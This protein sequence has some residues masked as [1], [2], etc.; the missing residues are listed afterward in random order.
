[1]Q[2]AQGGRYVV[3]ISNAFGTAFSR[4][5]TLSVVERTN[6]PVILTPPTSL[7]CF[8]GQTAT[9]TVEASGTPPLCYQWFRDEVPL[10]GQTNA[11]LVFPSVQFA[12]AGSYS[13]TVSNAA[14]SV[15]CGY[16]LLTVLPAAGQPGSV[17]P[18]F[19][20]GFGADDAVNALALRPDGRILIGGA[21]TSFDGVPREHLAQ[22]HGDGQVD[23][24]FDPGTGADFNL[25]AVA[26]QRDGQALI[27]G[28]FT[29]FNGQPQRYLARLRADGSVDAG[30]AP[31]FNEWGWVLAVAVQND[32]RIVIGG[33][34][35]SVNGE[36]RNR[37]ARLNADGSLDA[38][39]QPT[40]GVDA[41][42]STVMTLAVQPDGKV[43]LGGVFERVNG[44]ARRHIARLNAD[45]T[46][47][48]T[49]DPGTGAD[50]TVWAVAWQPD[51]KIVMGGYFTSVHGVSR[52]GIARLHANGS[53]D[54]SFDPG[55]GVAHADSPAVHGLALQSD[56]KIL[57]AG[58]FVVMN[59]VRRTHL[60]RL[61]PDGSLDPA[62][63]AD[64]ECFGWGGGLSDVV[65]QPDGQVLIAGNLENVNGTP[66]RGIARLHNQAGVPPCIPA[67]ASLVAWWPGNRDGMDVVGG[68]HGVSH[69]AA[70]APG[71]VGPAF[72]FDGSSYLEVPEAPALRLQS[73][74]TIEFWVRRERLEEPHYIV[75]KGGDWT[76][77]EQNYAVAL[78]T[79]AY[80]HCLHFLFAGGW[81][82]GGRIADTNWHHCAV[83]ARHGETNPALYIDGVQ[84]AV[85]YGEGAETIEL[86]PSTRPL[87][88]GAQIDPQSGWFYYHRGRI[89][90]LSFYDRVLSGGEIEAIYRA[91]SS[92]KCLTSAPPAFVERRIETPM[93]QLATTPP[94]SVS[95]YAVEDQPP[96]GWPVTNISHSGVWDGATG[97]VKFG[98]FYDA[99][100]RA[101][102]YEVG[103][104]VWGIHCALG[105]FCFSGRA[106][107]D[108][109]NS[110]VGGQ[111]CLAL[112][113]YFPADVTPADQQISIGEVTA[114][115]AAWRRGSNWLCHPQGIPIDYVTRAAF[116]WRAGEC[117]VVDPAIT[118]QPLWWVA[119]GTSGGA[120]VQSAGTQVFNL[121]SA[122][123]QMPAVFVPGEPFTVTVATQ[124]GTDTRAHAVE[125]AIPTGWTVS[126][127]NG[128]GDFDAAGGKVKWGPF[129]DAT[130]RTL[131]YR[132]NPP[133]TA[134]GI[135]SFSGVM[136][137]DGASV[138]I[139]GAGQV[140]EACRITLISPPASGPLQLTLSGRLGARCVVEA[141]SDLAT[142]TVLV[143]VTN[144][145]GRLMVTDPDFENHRARFYRARLLD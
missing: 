31:Q 42:G 45:G 46:L 76:W 13:V 7:T 88:I 126:A 95:V 116:L 134:L 63:A 111:Q 64:I 110:P 84:Q 144:T 49:F 53:L 37:I 39:F 100:P 21:F 67:P 90:E 101:L 35:T 16:A 55:T 60:A 68:N 83:T 25:Y 81:R 57:A 41:G 115:G 125:E 87:H 50:S 1:V 136:S 19:H 141:S 124:P 12:E 78:H 123:R 98:P 69:G 118:R 26:L 44:V 103:T 133:V 5:V 47:D 129:F 3:S 112:A 106:S 145:N 96:A 4:E 75:E 137:C 140:R 38:S 24:S 70:F 52:R 17:D 48:P 131:N 34:F 11:T 117:Y 10:S 79:G 128:G 97:K 119:C 80:D 29:S 105:V 114:Y 77:G 20:P 65:V 138:R 62:F 61:N 73:E 94:A 85:V 33:D 127:I 51:G 43:I 66:R 72:S 74:L 40:P 30:F 54:L 2:L 92:G 36:T 32:D 104:P 9:F 93:I 91:G 109:V 18:G 107:A 132:V 99:E 22:L 142:W 122:A 108:G 8:A 14:G 121:R 15:F 56:G 27:G 71:K 89:D 82:G 23:L 143:T 59:G 139:T 6:P 120:D 135:A 58:W 86:H 113:G 102:S 28:G 130:P